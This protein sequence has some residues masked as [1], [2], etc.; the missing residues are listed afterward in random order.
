MGFE[1]VRLYDGSWFE[2]GQPELFYP[3]ETSENRLVGGRLPEI[4]GSGSSRARKTDTTKDR[5]RRQ[6]PETP[7]GGYVSC[8]G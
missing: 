1:D 8:G 5:D 4:A 2:W 7:K 3:V 6:R